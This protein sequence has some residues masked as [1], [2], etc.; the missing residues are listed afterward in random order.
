MLQP[1]DTTGINFPSFKA[2]EGKLQGL[3][4]SIKHCIIESKETE[5]YLP[6]ELQE[7]RDMA[8]QCRQEYNALIESLKVE[9]LQP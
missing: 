9:P 7:F 3:K 6:E 4:S 2:I 1:F 8:E 5:T